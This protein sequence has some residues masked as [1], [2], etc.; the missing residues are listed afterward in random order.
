LPT[1]KS[2]TI[3]SPFTLR[4]SHQNVTAL[5]CHPLQEIERRQRGTVW[6]LFVSILFLCISTVSAY[7]KYERDHNGVMPRLERCYLLSFMPHTCDIFLQNSML[8]CLA[9][10]VEIGVGL[11][12][13]RFRARFPAVHCQVGSRLWTRFFTRVITS[14]P[15]KYYLLFLQNSVAKI[16]FS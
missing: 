6:R 3:A 10:Q 5:L 13:E 15:E 14:R 4:P 8:R 2:S 1:L 11:P 16:R 12:I 7:V 9:V